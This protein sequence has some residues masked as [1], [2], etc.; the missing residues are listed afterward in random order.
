MTGGV[1]QDK[2]IDIPIPMFLIV[3]DHGNVLLDTRMNPD[4]I[5]N[6]EEAWG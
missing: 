6:V 1:D 3:T 5:E 4:I 2:W